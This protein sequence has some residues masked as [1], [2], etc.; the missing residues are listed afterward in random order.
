MH[1]T[2][3]HLGRSKHLRLILAIVIIGIT[4]AY[5]MS[6]VSSDVIRADEQTTLGHVGGLGVYPDGITLIDTINSLAKYSA[7]HPPLYYLAANIWGTLFSYDSYIMRFLSVFWGILAIAVFYRLAADM[8]GGSAAFFATFLLATSTVFLFYTHEIREY[9]ALMFWVVLVWM[10]YSRAIRRRTPLE[11][12]HIL[13]L[14]VATTCAVYTHYTTIFLLIPMGI[15]HLLFVPKNKLWWQVSGA[16][17][18]AGL[19][20]LPWVPTMVS[21]FNHT[22]GEIAEDPSKLMTNTEML[23]MISRL[24]GNGQ[25]GLFGVLIGLGSLGALLNRRN[26]RYALFFLVG[27]LLAICFLNWQL[28]F[29]KRIRYVIVL[30]IPFCMLGGLGLSLIRWRIVPLI[31]LAVWIYQ[32]DKLKGDLEYLNQAQTLVT[33]YFIEYN[34]LVP[35]LK[36]NLTSDDLLVTIVN[37]NGVL[38]GSKQGGMSIED[39]YLS[40]L[41]LEH[42]NIFGKRSKKDFVLDDVLSAIDDR[43]SFWVAYKGG[44]GPE[45]EEVLMALDGQYQLCNKLLYGIDSKLEE[46]VTSY[47]FDT[48]CVEKVAS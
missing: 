9:S 23:T 8:G 45:F 15:Y 1:S 46:Y 3:A 33:Y 21:G 42:V 12:H 44:P 41:N 34:H 26:F 6:G 38:S 22:V 40:P 20:Y 36:D 39:Y 19:L 48:L 13:L 31:F 25:V 5:S 37:H 11:W 10:L 47:N 27:F 24:W 18:G 16:I 32:G 28:E 7:Q 29:V 17:I 30:W 4:Y 43:P 35:I 14:L 2:S